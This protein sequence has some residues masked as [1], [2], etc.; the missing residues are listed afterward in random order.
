MPMEVS[1]LVGAS[2]TGKSHRALFIAHKYNIP[3][4]IDDGILIRE[5]RVLAGKS[6]KREITRVGAV[7]RAIFYDEQHAR[8]VKEQIKASGQN[9]ILILAT[10]VKMAERIAA[11]LEL[12]AINNIMYIE[13]IATA[14]AIAKALLLRKHKNQHVIPIPTFE[15]KKDFPGYIIDPL[16]SLVQRPAANRIWMERSVVRPAYSSLGGFYISTHVLTQ[17]V[18]HLAAKNEGISKIHRA[19][20]KTSAD[21]LV[22]DL[23]MTLVLTGPLLPLLTALQQETKSELELMTGFSIDKINL[24]AKRIIIP[25]Q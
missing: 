25:E 17:L 14:K 1:A 21:G 7:K 2:G 6:A 24:T 11:R 18:E 22:V 4:I 8:E 10:S 15:I 12:P 19:G 23:E 16:K 9:K 20:F 5:T 13:D 3:L